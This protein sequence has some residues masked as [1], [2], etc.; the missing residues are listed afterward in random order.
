MLH[1]TETVL[2]A[3]LVAQTFVPLETL[4]KAKVPSHVSYCQAMQKKVCIKLVAARKLLE[5]F[6]AVLKI[7][8]FSC[9]RH[10]L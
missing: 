2:C 5:D 6:L 4:L 7:V 3:N 1:A 10:F 8:F 9:V